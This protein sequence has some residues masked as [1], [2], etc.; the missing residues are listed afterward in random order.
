[1]LELA[2]DCKGT[3]GCTG[4]I[5]LK[6][7]LFSYACTPLPSSLPWLCILRQQNTSQRY[8]FISFFILYFLSF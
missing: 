1:M 7:P 8:I 3:E 6:Q 5:P 2:L 4:A